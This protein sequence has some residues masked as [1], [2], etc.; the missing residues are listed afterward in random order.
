MFRLRTTRP[1]YLVQYAVI[2]AYHVM[3]RYHDSPLGC[4]LRTEH[5]D[6]QRRDGNSPKFHLVSPPLSVIGINAG[7][8]RAGE[9]L[10]LRWG[11]TILCNRVGAVRRQ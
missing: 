2:P 6:Y 4:G 11:F 7:R 9:T 10:R 8:D 1:D 5:A 3:K